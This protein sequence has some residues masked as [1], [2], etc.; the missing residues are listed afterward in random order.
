MADLRA[1]QVSAQDFARFD[2][3]I[4]MDRQN[5]RDVA[6]LRPRDNATPVQLLL[7]F[8]GAGAPH[9]VPDPYYTGDYAQALDLIEA[10][11]RGLLA[12]L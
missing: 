3:I 1:R 10:G 7:A 2:R 11:V 9:D 12:D 4:V 6:R 8:A 5:A